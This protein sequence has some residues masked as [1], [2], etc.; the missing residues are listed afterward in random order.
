MKVSLKRRIRIQIQFQV[1]VRVESASG[2]LQDQGKRF[3]R[4]G[5]DA[6]PVKCRDKLRISS[7]K[8]PGWESQR[9]C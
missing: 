7:R 4:Q 3:A 9:Q 8:A 2:L 5:D 6:G 1:G